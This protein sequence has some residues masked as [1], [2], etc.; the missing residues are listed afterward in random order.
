MKYIF[1]HLVF[2]HLINY[3]PFY[4]LV[5]DIEESEFDFLKN[6]NMSQFET[7]ILELHN[8]KLSLNEINFF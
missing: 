1:K 8:N 4:T 2:K 5:M 7:I 6:F 3:K